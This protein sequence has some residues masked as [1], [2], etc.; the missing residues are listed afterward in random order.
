MEY[1]E[2]MSKPTVIT[3]SGE[4]GSGTT[5]I[6]KLLN[7]ELKL[8][9]FFIGETFRVLAREYKMSLPEFGKYADTHPEI[10]FELDKRQ[11]ARAKRG[12]VIMEGRLSGWLMRKNNIKAFN[13]Y[14]MA[15]LAIRVKRIMGREEKSYDQVEREILEREKCEMD[16]YKKIYNI[17]YSDPVHYDLIIDTSNLTPEQIVKK[18]IDA[19][20]SKEI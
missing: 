16:R 15:D 4:P 14:L 17:D 12:N 20:S 2:R 19:Y 10:D 1:D 9:L 11:V 18:I 13:I 7:E 3:I 5:T 8:E 6:A